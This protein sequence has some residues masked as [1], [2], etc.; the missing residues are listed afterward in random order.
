[1]PGMPGQ[2]ASSAPSANKT[3]TT[4]QRNQLR[5]ISSFSAVKHFQVASYRR[6]SDFRQQ[7]GNILESSSLPILLAS[8]RD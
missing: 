4:A 6:L 7:T 8:D 5:M 1:M 3:A 2:P